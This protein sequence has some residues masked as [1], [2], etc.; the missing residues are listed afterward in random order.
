V[1]K[2]VVY[3]VMVGYIV[4]YHCLTLNMFNISIWHLF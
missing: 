3:I 4:D 2:G 1:I